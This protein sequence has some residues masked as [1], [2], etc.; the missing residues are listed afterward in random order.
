[1]RHYPAPIQHLQ[2]SDALPWHEH[3]EAYVAIVLDGGYSEAG[4]EGRRGVRAGD[5][6]VHQ[7]HCGHINRFERNGARVLNFTLSH[8]QSRGLPSGRCDDPQAL[9]EAMRAEPEE[10]ASL[11]RQAVTATGGAGD[12]P[13]LLA[14]CLRSQAQVR[15]DAWAAAHGVAERT[16]RRQFALTYGMSAAAYRARARARRAWSLIAGSDRP[17]I[18][19][20]YGLGFSDQAHLSRA[21]RQL[22]A[23]SPTT[24]RARGRLV[25]D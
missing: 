5:V 24:I 14:D 25:Q 7:P 19:I 16:L 10:R 6:V 18:D 4:D 21:M 2:A 15:L 17:L 20:G 9:A 23:M 13:D 12:L 1:M 22:S 8:A 3:D 11:I